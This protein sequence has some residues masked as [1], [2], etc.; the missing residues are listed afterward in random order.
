[1]CW[2]VGPKLFAGHYL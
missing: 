2:H 1:M